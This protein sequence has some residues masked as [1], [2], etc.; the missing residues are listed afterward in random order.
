MI[1]QD[2]ELIGEILE[3]T[4]TYPV[5]NIEKDSFGGCIQKDIESYEKNG[6]VIEAAIGNAQIIWPFQNDVASQEQLWLQGKKSL[7]D[8]LEY[9]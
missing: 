5:Q 2:K 7:E 3:F 6:E 1:V 8:V 9:D 4:Q